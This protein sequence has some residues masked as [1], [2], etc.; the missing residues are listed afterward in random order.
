MSLSDTG[1]YVAFAQDRIE[2]GGAETA[3]ALTREAGFL[4]EAAEM[5]ERRAARLP[6]L[7]LAGEL[8]ISQMLGQP[9]TL[10]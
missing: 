6:G 2:G 7:A 5:L 1:A 10:L 8:L 4:R 9:G 3:D